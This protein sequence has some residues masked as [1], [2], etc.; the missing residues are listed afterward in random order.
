MPVHS[1]MTSS[2]VILKDVKL[3]QP[4]VL[5]SFLDNSAIGVMTLKYIIENLKMS[6]F[7]HVSSPY[8]PPVTVF[9]AGKL[10]HP[11]RLYSD[12][13]GKYCIVISD[14]PVFRLSTAERTAS[15]SGMPSTVTARRLISGSLRR[16]DS[17]TQG[18]ASA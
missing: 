12:A 14:I 9:V 16:M 10:R 2:M 15:G 17:L 1:S 18:V 5:M 4:L 11:F 7:A 13:E 8:V 3:K 6:Q